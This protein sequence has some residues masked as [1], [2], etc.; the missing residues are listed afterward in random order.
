M[1]GFIQGA[2]YMLNDVRAA[3]SEEDTIIENIKAIEEEIRE[4]KRR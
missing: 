1:T 2:E 3:L 4:S